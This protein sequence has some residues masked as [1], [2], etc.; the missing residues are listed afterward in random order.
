MGLRLDP[1]TKYYL[2]PFCVERNVRWL[3]KI[4]YVLQE[5]NCRSSS[6]SDSNPSLLRGEEGRENLPFTS[7]LSSHC[8]CLWG[9][10][11]LHFICA[12][13]VQETSQTAEVLSKRQTAG[14]V[15]WSLSLR[16]GWFVD[17]IWERLN[18]ESGWERLQARA[19]CNENRHF[20]F[21][22]HCPVTDAAQRSLALPM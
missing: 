6:S 17:K 20:T 16:F 4:H 7:C 21:S 12:G 10:W 8:I 13:V 22:A 19:R 14:T 11:N 5:E 9:T 18:L 3:K 1:H 15:K 2:V